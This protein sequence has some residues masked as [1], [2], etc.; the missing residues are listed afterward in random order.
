MRSHPCAW[1]RDLEFR[2]SGSSFKEEK[3]RIGF[4]RIFGPTTTDSPKPRLYFFSD[5]PLQGLIHLKMFGWLPKFY[6]WEELCGLLMLNGVSWMIVF[7]SFSMNHLIFLMILY[8]SLQFKYNFKKNDLIYSYWKDDNSLSLEIHQVDYQCPRSYQKFILES[9]VKALAFKCHGNSRCAGFR[10]KISQKSLHTTTFSPHI[11][12]LTD[13]KC[14]IQSSPCCYARFFMT[15]SLSQSQLIILP[16]I[17]NNKF[18]SFPVMVCD[19]LFILKSFLPCLSPKEELVDCPCPMGR[20]TPTFLVLRPSESGLKAYI[21]NISG[22]QSTVHV[23]SWYFEERFGK[24]QASHLHSTLKPLLVVVINWEQPIP[25]Y[26]QPGTVLFFVPL[27][28]NSTLVFSFFFLLIPFSFRKLF[29]SSTL[30]QFCLSTSDFTLLTQLLNTNSTSKTQL[31]RLCSI[32]PTHL[33]V[34]FP[35]GEKKTEINSTSIKLLKCPSLPVNL[36]DYLINFS[37]EFHQI[38][39]QKPA[40]CLNTLRSLHS[41]CSDIENPTLSLCHQP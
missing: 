7:T 21:S 41:L 32:N 38:P 8:S 13:P 3:E 14:F 10:N 16:L 28:W 12:L 5:F 9:Y 34:S 11:V 39:L 2:G 18:I 22:A 36:Q 27:C 20:S 1:V 15:S 31:H 37:I 26:F 4:Q 35:I 6:W 40:F 23:N 29:N 19:I 25:K 24:I 33:S 30:S 17:K